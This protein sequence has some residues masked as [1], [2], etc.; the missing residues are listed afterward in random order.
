MMT[1]LEQQIE[2]QISQNFYYKELSK[3]WLL[4]GFLHFRLV[5]TLFWTTYFYSLMDDEVGR[6]CPR[7][8]TQLENRKPNVVKICNRNDH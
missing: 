1:S 5:L 7:D 8:E 2:H 4:L 6:T 3:Y